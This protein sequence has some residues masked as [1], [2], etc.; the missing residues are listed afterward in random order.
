MAFEQLQ[1][2][3]VLR[4]KD[5]LL[6][7]VNNVVFKDWN[8]FTFVSKIIGY[9]EFWQLLFAMIQALYPI[10]RILRLADMKIGGMDKLK[11]YV[12][13]T[14]RL[15]DAGVENVVKKWNDPR[16]PSMEL[17][18][19]HLNSSDKKFLAGLSQLF[20]ITFGHHLSHMLHASH[21]QTLPRMN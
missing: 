12:L 18:S 2:I 13:Q 5:A 8:R 3:R 1:F 4:L 21:L 10:Y 15:L 9:D 7:T 20:T 11:F 6:S 19:A 16:M 17:R 14:D